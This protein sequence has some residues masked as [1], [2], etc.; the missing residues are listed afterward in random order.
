ME[1]GRC[2]QFRN[3]VATIESEL[4]LRNFE[5]S[6]GVDVVVVVVVS[7]R[8]STLSLLNSTTHPTTFQTRFDFDSTYTGNAF[9]AYAYVPSTRVST[10]NEYHV[11]HIP[12]LVL[13][14]NIFGWIRQHL[15]QLSF[16]LSLHRYTSRSRSRYETGYNILMYNYLNNRWIK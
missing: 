2:A 4:Q 9:N 7:V 14:W 12:A 15:E 8:G 16:S 5:V 3:T 6:Q 10:K 13:D 11:D 1:L